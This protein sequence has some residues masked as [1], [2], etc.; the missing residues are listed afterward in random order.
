MTPLLE[1]LD[2]RFTASLPGECRDAL[3][4]LVFEHPLQGRRRLSILD[5]M[6]AHGA[7]RIAGD[8]VLRVEVEKIPTAQNLFVL[9]ETEGRVRLLGFA[10]Y[11]RVGEHLDILFLAVRHAYTD[12]GR[13]ARFGLTYRLMAEL[14][15]IAHHVKVVAGVRLRYRKGQALILPV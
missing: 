10:L 6:H 5:N 15:R 12:G 7:P 8:A 11:T 3:G 4:K 13:L 9:T 14:K 2:V 1:P